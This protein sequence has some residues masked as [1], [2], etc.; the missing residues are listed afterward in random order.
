MQVHDLL[1]DPRPEMFERLHRRRRHHRR[2]RPRVRSIDGDLTRWPEVGDRGRD[3]Q[4]RPASRTLIC[5]AA[6]GAGRP[7]G[8]DHAYAEYADEDLTAT[9]LDT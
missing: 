5:G 6:E 9:P 7:G 4:R 3:A 2:V 1:T 8:P